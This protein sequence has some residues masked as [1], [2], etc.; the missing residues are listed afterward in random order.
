MAVAI[1]FP[2]ETPPGFVHRA[3]PL[4][5]TGERITMVNGYI[6]VD[7]SVEHHGG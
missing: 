1:P 6:S 5:E 2:G 7:A 3:A 4:T